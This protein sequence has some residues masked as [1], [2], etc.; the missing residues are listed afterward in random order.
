MAIE[1]L[2][3][4]KVEADLTVHPESGPGILTIDCGTIYQTPQI[5]MGNSN[6]PESVVMSS[7]SNPGANYFEIKYDNG[8]TGSGEFRVKNAE[9][10]CGFGG[11][12]T[13]ITRVS[14]TGLRIAGGLQLSGTFEDSS[15]DVGTSGQ[16]L[17]STATGTNWINAGGSGSS[18]PCLIASGGGRVYVTNVTDNND[19][20]LVLGGSIGFSYY[21]WSTQMRGATSSFTGLGIPGTTTTSVT[22]YS[23]VQGAFQV[24]QSGTIRIQ[25][26]C[27][28]QNNS[29]V[30]NDKVYIYVFKLPP[31][32]VAAMGNGSG[33]ANSN[34]TLVA[35]AECTMPSTGASQRPQS[36][37]SS[38][39]E[40]VTAG[41]WVFASLSFA[42]TVTATRYFYTNF[43]MSTS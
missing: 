38:N 28:G 19:R 33:Q 17:S 29:E 25:G 2:D 43:S 12:S 7:Y 14:S 26:T 22:P 39:G 40:T 16:V 30:Y 34:Y 3:D 37:E 41:D 6:S 1:F 23:A 11:G 31:N 32:I 4:V 42:G 18:G 24:R 5:K 8:A 15:G 27:E 21:N 13:P 36:F 20:A 10:D 9:I 35:S